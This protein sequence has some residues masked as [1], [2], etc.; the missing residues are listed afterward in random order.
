MAMDQYIVEQDGAAWKI[1]YDGSYVGIFPS[2][3]AAIAWAIERAR[4]ALARGGRA[5]V[6]SQSEGCALCMEWAS[7][8]A[9]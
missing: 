4:N 8:S 1:R 9:A 3:E 2:K 5:C 7:D 6:L